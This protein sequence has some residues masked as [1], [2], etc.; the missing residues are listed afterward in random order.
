MKEKQLFGKAQKIQSKDWSGPVYSEGH[1]Y[2]DGYFQDLD[3]FK[4]YCE[5]E[6]ID[7]PRYVWVAKREDL[8]FVLDFDWIMERET[9]DIGC[10]YDQFD[11]NTQ[12]KGVPELRRAFEEFN[13]KNKNALWT[14]DTDYSKAIL[15]R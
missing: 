11:Y 5:E 3:D 12:L 6:E 15:L 10:H 1:G 7:L 2:E 4:T 8:P 14:W 13:S 9:E